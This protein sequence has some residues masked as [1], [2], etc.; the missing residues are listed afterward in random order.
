MRGGRTIGPSG[1]HQTVHLPG[2]GTHHPV[3]GSVR[4]ACPTGTPVPLPR[5]PAGDILGFASAH[6]SGWRL[7]F[8][9][10]GTSG[11]IARG[12]LL[13]GSAGGCFAAAHRARRPHGRGVEQDQAGERD[14]LAAKRHD[15]DDDRRD[16]RLPECQWIPR[17]A[18][19]RPV[20][21]P[22]LRDGAKAGW[23]VGQ[24]RHLRLV[25]QAPRRAA[26][27][28][29]QRRGQGQQRCHPD[30]GH[31]DHQR[32]GRGHAAAEPRSRRRSRP[33][34]L[35]RRPRRPSQ[36]GKPT[37]PVPNATGATA[38]TTPS[39]TGFGIVPGDT[40]STGATPSPVEASVI[41]PSP[42]PS[43]PPI[44]AGVLGVR[45]WPPSHRRRGRRPRPMAS[46]RSGSCPSARPRS[47]SRPRSSSRPLPRPSRRPRPAFSASTT[48]PAGRAAAIR[49]P[50]VPRP[51]R[52]GGGS[53]P[54]LAAD[55]GPPRPRRT[56]TANLPRVRARPYAGDH[57]RCRHGR[58]GTR[59]VRSSSPRGRAGQ[60]RCW[61][62]RQAAAWRRRLRR[63]GRR[64]PGRARRRGGRR[65]RAAPPSLAT[66]VAAPGAQGR[67]D[68][69][70]GSGPAA[71]LRRGPRRIDRGA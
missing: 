3:R 60:R 17:R 23:V 15:R 53:E 22:R 13:V 68:P 10:Q 40:G 46:R 36:A 24:G 41:E 38:T 25:R 35:R 14:R 45:S 7:I 16:G 47:R 26:R 63:D 42:S 71:D 39:V 20:R 28:G 12:T 70:C 9:P 66:P 8:A 34:G 18:R 31:G 6:D 21:Q 67:P 61:P 59:P 37:P 58:D 52:R 51:R 54:R 27:R 57:D 48:D 2:G 29:H 62:S 19:L 49:V 44:T 55:G 69:R 56:P 1:P 30:G 32:T 50:A 4:T 33:P 11:G 65:P 64:S 43:E 5:P